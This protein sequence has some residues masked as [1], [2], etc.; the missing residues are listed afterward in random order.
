MKL[1]LAFLVS[2]VVCLPVSLFAQEEVGVGAVVASEDAIVSGKEYILQSQAVG[3]PYIVDA[4]S[5][6]SIPNSQNK[7]TTAAVYTLTRAADGTWRICNS[8][9]GKYWGIPVYGQDLQ[10]VSEPE[11]GAWS[12][13][14]SGGVAYPSAPDAEG[15]ERGLDR[16]SQH[17]WG[18]ST[19]TG[20]TKR[21]KI[22]EL[23]EKPISSEPLA[24]LSGR[25]AEMQSSPA[26][27]LVAG[28]WYVMFDRGK[29]GTAA[30]GYLYEKVSAHTLYNTAT[31][32][33]SG[34]AASQ[35]RYLVRLQEA[36]EGL[37]YLQTGFG[38]YFGGLTHK[39][40]VSLT[41]TAEH[42]FIVQKINGTDGHFYLQDAT[43]KVVLDANSLESGDATVV[44]WNTTVPKSTGGNNDWAFYPVDVAEVGPEVAL[45]ADDIEVTRGYQTGG[46]GNANSLLLRVKMT[47]SQDISN[48]V[49]TFSLNDAA[50]S[51]LSS[52]CLYETS[53]LEFMANIPGTPL[54]TS[55]E[56]SGEVR[57]HLSDVS[58]ATHYFWLCATIKEEAELG[59]IIQAD[60]DA[61]EYTTTE[62]VRLEMHGAGAPDRQGMKIFSQQHFVFLPTT[63]NCRFYRIPAMILDEGGNLVVAADKRYNSNSDLGNHKIDVVSLRSLDGGRTWQD[64]ARVASGDGSTAAC[65]GYG[66]AALARATNG[67]LICMMAAGNKMWGSNANDG[68]KY[69]GFARST[70]DGKNWT[71]IKNLFAST[72]FYDENSEDGSLSMA[73]IFTSSGKG[74]TTHDGIIMFTTNC[75]TPGSSGPNLC[76]ILYSTDNGAH[77]RLSNAL[78][79]EGCDESKVE[80]LNDGSLLLS[81]RQSGNRGWN[82]GTYT[83]NADGTISFQWGQQRRTA[84]L[85]GNAC[86]A[87]LLCYSRATE[88]LPDIMLHSYINSAGRQSLQL[89]MSLNQGGSWKSVY[90]I[91][92][93][94]SCYS[95]MIVLPDGTLAILYEDESYSAGNGYAINYVTITR[96]QILGW[97]TDLGGVL[98]NGIGEIPQ[99]SSAPPHATTWHD[100]SGRSLLTTPT[101]RGLYLRDGKKVVVR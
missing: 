49:L 2:L 17:L 8:Y 80:Q 81:V 29:N 64:Y 6:Y 3:T 99:A 84:D 23:G 48:T 38:N 20:A 19:G 96:E 90:N 79:Y 47:P 51:N 55:E 15:V 68:M 69:A 10:P 36:G 22:Y 27:N 37:F 83:L 4:G 43:S 92:P 9:T 14:F 31:P 93:N 5:Y 89:S 57:F 67:T 77:W 74:L 76:Y 71:L 53:Q 18:Y 66:D 60:L 13:H 61:V 101:Q 82:N 62:D 42:A 40:V 11:A 72:L 70:T 85:W 32:P 86:N 78:A 41:A 65:F 98:P 56:V 58:A 94:G 95:T 35:A 39:T 50:V 63:D 25:T 30:H 28:Q 87:D 97:Y 26:D 16:S 91:Q 12:L 34:L 45:F 7:P 88:G 52:L 46:R 54:A 24:E 100:L 75:R 59:K 73:N 1:S 21:V 33:S 44:G